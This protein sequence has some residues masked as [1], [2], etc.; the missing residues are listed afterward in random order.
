M[1]GWMEG[2]RRT[3]VCS[4][5]GR[6]VVDQSARLYLLTYAAALEEVSKEVEAYRGTARMQPY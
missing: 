6:G 2:R 3:H 1:D 5:H 4:K